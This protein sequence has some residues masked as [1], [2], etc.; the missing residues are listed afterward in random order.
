MFKLIGRIST[1]L[2]VLFVLFAALHPANDDLYNKGI[3]SWSGVKDTFSAVWRVMKG[4]NNV[5]NFVTG[6]ITMGKNKLEKEKNYAKEKIKKEYQQSKDEIKK[7]I[8]HEAKKEIKETIKEEINSTK[9]EIIKK[10]KD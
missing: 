3:L 1:V 8:K 6:Y 7:T 4:D 2:V 5:N 10:L 9:K